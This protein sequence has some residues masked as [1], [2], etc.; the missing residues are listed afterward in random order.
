MLSNQGPHRAPWPQD[1]SMTTLWYSFR[2]LERLGGG[3]TSH[4]GFW[5]GFV[6]VVE[7]IKLEFYVN[8]MGWS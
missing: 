6:A 5:T 7:T 8:L 4:F 1:P 3:G 2:P